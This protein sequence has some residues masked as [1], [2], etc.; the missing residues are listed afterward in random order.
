MRYFFP[1]QFPNTSSL[2]GFWQCSR[3]FLFVFLVRCF[4]EVQSYEFLLY[5]GVPNQSFAHL[6]QC[7]PIFLYSNCSMRILLASLLFLFSLLRSC[8]VLHVSYSDQSNTHHLLRHIMPVFM[9]FGG[10]PSIDAFVCATEM[11][12]HVSM[13]VNACPLLSAYN[14]IYIYYIQYV[15]AMI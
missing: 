13:C 6:C 3:L 4:Y 14:N 5:L 8:V 1:F 10:I 9:S 15:Y 7:G 12:F 11:Y 2:W